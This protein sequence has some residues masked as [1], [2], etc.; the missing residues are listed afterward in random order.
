MCSCIYLSQFKITDFNPCICWAVDQ[1]MNDLISHCSN[2]VT[3][4]LIVLNFHC[5]IRRNIW[6]S[7][8]EISGKY[9]PCILIWL[10]LLASNDTSLPSKLTMWKCWCTP[11][12]HQTPNLNFVKFYQIYMKKYQHVK[13]HVNSMRIYFIMDQMVLIWYFKCWSLK[14]VELY[15]DLPRTKLIMDYFF[16][17][18]GILWSCFFP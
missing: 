9:Q 2:H 6:Y 13:C 3:I 10:R 12:C 17:N 4:T 5:L 15:K 18:L 11:L 1:E 16:H 8:Y 14:L 7:S